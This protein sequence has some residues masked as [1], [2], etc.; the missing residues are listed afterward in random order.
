MVD[1]ERENT[2]VD[3]RRTQATATTGLGTP[4]NYASV[5]ALRTRLAAADAGYY[6]AARLNQM[7]KNDLIYA[8]RTID[9]TAGI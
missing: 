1:L 8:L 3:K 5:D 2:F 4:A 6:T 9:D 7:T